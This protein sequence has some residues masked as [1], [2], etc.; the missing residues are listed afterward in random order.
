MGNIETAWK[1]NDKVRTLAVAFSY[2]Q[3]QVTGSK[4]P[5]PSRFGGRGTTT[6]PF[7]GFSST[8]VYEITDDTRKPVVIETGRVL[9]PRQP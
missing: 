7:D 5:D 3:L 1:D 6:D 2:E 9:N 8:K 4:N